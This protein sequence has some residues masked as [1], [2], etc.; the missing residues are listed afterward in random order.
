MLNKSIHK[1]RIKNILSKKNYSYLIITP[2]ITQVSDVHQDYYKYLMAGNGILIDDWMENVV[3][4]RSVGGEA[5]LLPSNWNALDLNFADIK[6]II[7]SIMNLKEKAE[8]R[9]SSGIN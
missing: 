9:F 2:K 4:F 5:I 6:T 3:K 1:N 8:W 7:G